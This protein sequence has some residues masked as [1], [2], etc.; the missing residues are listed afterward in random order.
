MPNHLRELRNAIVK[1]EVDT[2]VETTTISVGAVINPELRTQLNQMGY[3]N[4]IIDKLTKEEITTII[5]EAILPE[6]F[7]S[8][9]QFIQ[10]NFDNI[11]GE[12]V[13]ATT[14]P[15]NPDFE[16]FTNEDNVFKKC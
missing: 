13:A 10:E 16:M 11:V 3:K 6:N 2:E 12:L 9:N 8:R 5:K 4:S 15:G 14:I 7:V 1:S